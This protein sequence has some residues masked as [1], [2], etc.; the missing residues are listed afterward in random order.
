LLLLKL[1]QP[2]RA[3]GIIRTSRR[4]RYSLHRQGARLTRDLCRG[5]VSA[6]CGMSRQ[7]QHPIATIDQGRYF[8][9]L[10][11]ARRRINGRS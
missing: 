1:K 3:S 6:F 5:N 4:I 10:M 8:L 2:P 11:K 7:A 9:C